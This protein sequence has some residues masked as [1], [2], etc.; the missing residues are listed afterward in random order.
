MSF[1]NGAFAYLL[2]LLSELLEFFSGVLHDVAELEI[3]V[4]FHDSL[5]D[6]HH[7]EHV[8][9]HWPLRRSWVFRFLPLALV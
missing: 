9:V 2:F 5:A 8:L 4:L 6:V 7:V 3:W 1:G